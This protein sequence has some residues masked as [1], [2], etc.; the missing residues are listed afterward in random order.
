VRTRGAAALAHA[1]LGEHRTQ[2]LDRAADARGPAQHL[3]PAEHRRHR[4]VDAEQIV[5]AEGQGHRGHVVRLAAGEQGHAR[6]HLC[7]RREQVP[8]QRRR[9]R[10]LEIEGHDFGAATQDGGIE[11]VRVVEPTAGA[12]RLFQPGGQG[13][14]APARAV[15][16]KQALAQSHVRIL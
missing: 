8:G 15:E 5:R 9:L 14:G 2:P 6:R 1:E 12:A 7:V 11:L 16:Q 13:R 3:D 10:V 4:I